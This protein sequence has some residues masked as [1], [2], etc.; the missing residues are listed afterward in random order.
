MNGILRAI[1]GMMQQV[2]ANNETKY[3]A[4]IGALQQV[5][6]RLRESQEGSTNTTSGNF[7]ARQSS[8]SPL[9][10]KVRHSPEMLL[11]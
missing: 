2:V 7:K 4:I 1:A 5:S 10:L 9:E 3:Q 6:S 8:G 11:D